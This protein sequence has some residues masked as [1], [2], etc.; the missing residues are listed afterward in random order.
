MT[1]VGTATGQALYNRIERQKG[2]R[3]L[4][5]SFLLGVL[6]AGAMAPVHGVFLLVP[7]FTGLLWLIFSGPGNRN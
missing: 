4:A 1:A 6:A 7:A 3:R 5:L 2:W